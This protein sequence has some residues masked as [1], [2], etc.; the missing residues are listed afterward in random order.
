MAQK[1]ILSD[2][3]TWIALFNQTRISE[4]WG[5]WTDVHFRLKN[6][7]IKDPSQFLIRVGPTYYITDDVRHTVAYNFINHF[8]DEAHPGI[9]Q[10]EHR[11]FQQLQWYTRF[12]KTRLMQ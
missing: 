5:S 11:P 3:Q 6:D 8:P 12:P 9:S 4:K 2:D 1:T 7:F 10:S